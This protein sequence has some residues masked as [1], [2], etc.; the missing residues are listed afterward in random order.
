MR[1]GLI[2]VAAVAAAF[3]TRGCGKREHRSGIS[4]LVEQHK[5]GLDG[6]SV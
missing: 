5:H 2:A 6:S 3:S 4:L 1:K